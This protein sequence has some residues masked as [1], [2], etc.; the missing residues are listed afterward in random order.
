MHGN[1]GWCCGDAANPNADPNPNQGIPKTL[2]Q[3]GCKVFRRQ[4]VRC[5]SSNRR[6][7]ADLGPKYVL[8]ELGLLLTTAHLPQ[9]MNFLRTFFSLK[10]SN[11]ECQPL[12][13]YT[14]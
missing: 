3:G 12:F 10:S 5:Q 9:T 11:I 8:D 14:L 4:S 1:N 2:G 6:L 7:T 13:T